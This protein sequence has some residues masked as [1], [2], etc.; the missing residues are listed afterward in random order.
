MPRL[1]AARLQGLA[2]L[3]CLKVGVS[4]RLGRN[5]ELVIYGELVMGNDV[6]I[7][8][9]AKLQVGPGARLVLGDGAYVGR[10]S[11]IAAAEC[12]EVGAFSHIGEHCSVRDSDHHTDPKTRRN[13]VDAPRSTVRIA[14]DVWIGAGA[15]VLR[16]SVIGEGSI[17]AA[18]A[19]VKGTVPPMAMAGGVPARVIKSL[20]GDGV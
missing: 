7:D 5:V 6:V 12:I 8:D 9:G 11:V 19:V 1:R 17:V 20:G 18:N 4:P 15:R 13:E 3:G 2:A 14:S 10:G 16:G